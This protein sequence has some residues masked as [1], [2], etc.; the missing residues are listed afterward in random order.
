MRHVEEEPGEVLVV[1]D[2]E[3]ASDPR[4][5]AFAVVLDVARHERRGRQA[6][7]RAALTS[8]H[9]AHDLGRRFRLLS[10]RQAARASSSG[11]GKE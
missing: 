2:D 4:R 5:D 6:A 1:V 8:D 9:H 7:S 11:A 3:A 10:V